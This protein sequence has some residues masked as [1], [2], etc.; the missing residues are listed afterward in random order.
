VWAEKQKSPAKRTP[1]KLNNKEFDSLVSKLH[2]SNKKKEQTI[3]AQ[4]NANLAAELQHLQFKPELNKKSRDETKD[5]KKLIERQDGMIQK[6]NAELQKQRDAARVLEMQECTFKPM[7][8]GAK[9]GTILLKRAGKSTQGKRADEMLNWEKDK[10]TRRLQRKQIVEE[11]EEAELSFAPHLNRRSLMLT[12]KMRKEGK[13]TV[14]RA[15]GQTASTPRKHAGKLAGEL[16]AKA[17][18]AGHE[19]ETFTPVINTRSAPRSGKDVHSRLYEK[20]VEQHVNKHNE[21]LVLKKRL[22]KEVPQ[23]K[24]ETERMHGAGPAAWVQSAKADVKNRS[25]SQDTMIDDSLD[26][27]INVLEYDPKYNFILEKIR[28]SGQ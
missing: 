24:W 11:M 17:S 10:E 18:V 5:M 27:P 25:F 9:K 7:L 13:Y 16:A 6:K 4:S 22:L 26:P 23:K 14:D 28:F 21:Q 12:E 20:A 8:A 3:M 1:P 2:S 15:T 19:E